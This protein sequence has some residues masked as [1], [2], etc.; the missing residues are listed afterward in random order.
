MCDVSCVLIAK[1]KWSLKSRR[2]T[3]LPGWSLR[4][5]PKSTG[6]LSTSNLSQLGS[7]LPHPPG[8]SRAEDAGSDLQLYRGEQ[9]SAAIW[10]P[11]RAQRGRAQHG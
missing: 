10:V 2:L 11:V 5:V 4:L 3:S 6:R 9:S 7:I 1:E 8:F